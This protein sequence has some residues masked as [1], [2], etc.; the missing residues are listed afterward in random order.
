MLFVG[1]L[2]NVNDS[3]RGCERQSWGY[4]SMCNCVQSTG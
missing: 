3:L 1:V 4:D 2:E